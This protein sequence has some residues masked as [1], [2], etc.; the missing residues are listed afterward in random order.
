MLCSTNILKNLKDQPWCK[1]NAFFDVKTGTHVKFW[2]NYK[3]VSNNANKNLHNYTCTA[4]LKTR[5]IQM[6]KMLLSGFLLWNR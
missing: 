6:D 3:D 5:D 2:I 1:I 4:V